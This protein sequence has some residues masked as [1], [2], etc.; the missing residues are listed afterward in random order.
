MVTKAKKGVLE[1]NILSAV[2]HDVLEVGFATTPVVLSGA[3]VTPD[4]TAGNVFTWPI[5]ANS[6]LNN[7]S[8]PGAGVWYIYAT[9][10]G[11]S[12]HTMSFGGNFN[13]IQGSQD[14]SAN[15]VNIYTIV[16][17]GSEL[18]LFINQRP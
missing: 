2:V 7:P 6:T 16:S 4:F 17:D 10:D 13:I 15:A 14:S 18:D 8:I 5:T 11:S 1:D 3:S 12:G 9:N